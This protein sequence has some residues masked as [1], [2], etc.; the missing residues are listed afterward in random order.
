MAILLKK[1]Y[2]V[3]LTINSNFKVGYDP[4]LT[5]E[6]LLCLL[7][8][9]PK[10]ET[11]IAEM[12][13]RLTTVERLNEFLERALETMHQLTLL[14]EMRK[15]DI[16][17]YGY[18]DKGTFIRDYYRNKR[19]AFER[20]FQ[21]EVFQWKMDRYRTDDPE[22]IYDTYIQQGKYSHMTEVALFA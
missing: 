14:V 21:E 12:R 2:V 7:D 17:A 18:K 19:W 5:F 6:G 11:L 20:M 9:S 22:R 3:S 15:E 8:I 4:N 13:H 1:D 16:D 10:A